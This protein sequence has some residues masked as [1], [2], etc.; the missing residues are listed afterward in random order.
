L[1]ERRN[2]CESAEY[3]VYLALFGK[4]TVKVG[5][6]TLR[7]VRTRWIEQGADYG[8]VVEVIKDGRAARRVESTIGRL[9][10]VVKQVRTG[11]K[12]SEMRSKLTESEAKVA[13]DNF[14]AAQTII[15]NS[16]EIELVDLSIH[17]GL[18]NVDS[19]P[20]L[21]YKNSDGIIGQKMLGEIVGAKGSLLVT[22][23]AGT[24]R[25]ANLKRLIG[26]TVSTESEVEIATQSGLDD[27]I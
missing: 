16:G 14:V 25:V 4:S 27:F 1:P 10:P 6:S 23:I 24:Y 8:A 18:D 3:A 2:A 13:L 11:R 7:R 22:R 19:E 26:Y 21:W 20:Q 9:P 17:Y 15:K 12:A 5:V